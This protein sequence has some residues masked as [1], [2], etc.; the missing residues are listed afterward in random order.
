MRGVLVN[1]LVSQGLVGPAV[2]TVAA[3]GKERLQP[4]KRSV[5]SPGKGVFTTFER[6]VVLEF[7]GGR[8]GEVAASSGKW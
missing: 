3:V 6:S 2:P 8:W 4:S 5:R 7:Y 1:P